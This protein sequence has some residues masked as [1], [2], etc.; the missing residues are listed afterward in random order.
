MP[1]FAYPLFLLL[2]PLAPLVAWRHL[3]RRRPAVRFPD[4]SLFAGLPVGRA[5]RARWGG[6][7]LRGFVVAAVVLAAANPRRPDLRTPVPVDGIAI[8]LSLDVSGSMAQPDFGTAAAPLSRLDAAKRAFHLFVEG[9]IAPDGTTVE[10]RPNDQLALVTFAAVPHTTCPLTLNHSVLLKVLDE[11]QPLDGIHAGTNI[12]DALAEAAIRLLA[13][14]DRPK[15]IVLL[16]DGEHNKSG[17]SSL[18]PLQTADLARKLGIP[19]HTIDCGGNGTTVN[20]DE[21][22]QRAD[23]RATLEAVAA[24]TGGRAFVADSG[25]ELRSVLKTIDGLERRPAPAPRYR[26]YHDYGPWCGLAAAILLI[27][28]ATLERT[29]WRTL[30]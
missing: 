16:S 23:G 8:A 18:L 6:S 19:V 11:Q 3:R 30:P 21:A 22:R 15:V 17:D 7:L 4:S 10:G 2:L 9:G 5:A 26:R 24:S 12:G 20:P 1:G 28:F 13:A 25:D 29:R 27:L 14:G